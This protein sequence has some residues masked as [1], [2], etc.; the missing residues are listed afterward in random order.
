[1][2]SVNVSNYPLCKRCGQRIKWSTLRKCKNTKFCSF[3]CYCKNKTKTPAERLRLKSVTKLNGCIEWIGNKNNKGY[4]IME[5]AGRTLAC[6]RLAWELAN[7]KKVPNN[8]CVC[9]SCDNPP[10]INPAHLWIG[11]RA[12]N[13]ID[14]VNK[15]RHAHG[16]N[17]NSRLTEQ[18]VLQI[19]SE[20]KGIRGEYRRIAERLGVSRSV[21][22]DV[23]QRKTWSHI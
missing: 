17:S 13:H 11:T 3:Q 9:H 19:R 22:E 8:M 18:Q 4:G 21:I 7:N 6:H 10:C 23:V 16:K 14:M 1:M 20:Y 15:N 12:D 5:V 2:S